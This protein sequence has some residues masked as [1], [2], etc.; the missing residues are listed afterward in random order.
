MCRLETARVRFSSALADICI[1]TSPVIDVARYL[2]AL[3]RRH[4]GR[5]DA[6][7]HAAVFR[8]AGEHR[9]AELVGHR[10]SARRRLGRALDA[11]RRSAWRDAVAGAECGRLRRLR[12]GLERR[13]G[14]SWPQAQSAGSGARRDRLD[15]RRHDARAGGIGAAHDDRRRHR[16]DLCGADGR[17]IVVGAPQDAA[18]ALAGDRRAGAA[19][20]RADA[21]DPARRPVA[22]A[23]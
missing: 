3:F 17:R 1:T 7:S 18:K 8:Q 5:G 19:R 23:R 15:R 11:R 14:L 21:A 13:A 10:L 6:G 2:H 4:D 22:S 20:L 12:H 16:R 9:G